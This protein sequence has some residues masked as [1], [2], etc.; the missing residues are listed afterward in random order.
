MPMDLAAVGRKRK[1]T[2]R[3]ELASL[4]E[5]ECW[6]GQFVVD[7]VRHGSMAVAI[8]D[9]QLP[10]AGGDFQHRFRLV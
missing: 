3:V 1:T 6:L 4:I 7:S 2:K 8:A 5:V 10:V 9:G